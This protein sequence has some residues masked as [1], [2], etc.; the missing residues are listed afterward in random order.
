MRTIAHIS[1]L[2]FG[3]VEQRAADALVAD[4][5][6]QKFDLLICSGDFTQRARV[7]QYRTAAAFMK[8][9]PGPQITVPGN[10]DIPLWNMF[11]RFLS[12]L[13]Q[14]RRFINANL[15]PV[16]QD[17]EIFVLGMNTARPFTA[18][19]N[20]FWKDGKISSSQL[21]EL[22]RIYSQAPLAATK[23]LVTHHPFIPPQG[24]AA[25]NIMHGT[26]EAL[27]ELQTCGVDLLLAGHLHISYL[28][29][30]RSHHESVQR[31]M[32]SIQAGTAIS[33]RRR[34]QSNG[35][36]ILAI[37]PN[38]IAIHVRSFD[39]KNFQPADQ[40]TFVRIDEIWTEN[41]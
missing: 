38:K 26:T 6:Q 2:H 35:Y 33:T 31:S 10:H 22:R 4:L 29:D 8:R 19:F 18:S 20:G 14:Y 30:V 32:L 1:D 3:R 27:V 40:R 9:L 23:I 36:N 5:S 17:Q 11:R 24:P 15:W 37:E 21:V 13:G 39:G 28:G 34:D 12:P 7:G 41:C 25:Y 16:Y